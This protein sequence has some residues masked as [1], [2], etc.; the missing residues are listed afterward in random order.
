MGWKRDGNKNR[1][2]LF[3]VNAFEFFS[4]WCGRCENLATILL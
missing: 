2:K 1:N 4:K 3:S